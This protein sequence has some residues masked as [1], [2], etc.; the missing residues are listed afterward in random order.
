[1]PFDL[2]HCY[3]LHS[4]TIYSDGTLTPAGLIERARQQ[5]VDVLALTDHDTTDGLQEAAAAA[6]SRGLTL[7]DGVE[8][9]VTWG[10]RTVHIVG[11]R[12]DRNNAELQAGLSRLREFRNWRA[13]EIDR[14]LARHRIDNMLEAARSRAKGAIISRTHFAHELVA[15]GHAVDM[16]DAF[17]H[18]LTK[19]KPGYVPGEW[20]TLADAVGWIRAAGGVAVIAHPGRYQL[21]ATKLRELIAEFKA[22]GGT[23]IE[24]LSGSHGPNEAVHM[25]RV[26]NDHALLAS[27]GSDYHGPE[28]PWV[29]LGRLPPLSSDCVAVWKSWCG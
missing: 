12:I 6:A 3:D 18:F 20:A 24:V 14:R 10:S 29:E 1:M 25:A 23:A 5:G 21:T 15:R 19:G 11:L 2:N 28:K 26:A 22:A 17:R 9:S 13:Q 8:I 4:H 16:R 7:I 27:V